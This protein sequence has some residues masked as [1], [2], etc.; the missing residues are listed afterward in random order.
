MDLDNAPNRDELYERIGKA[1]AFLKHKHD[2]KTPEMWYSRRGIL[3]EYPG[4]FSKNGYI[5]MRAKFHEEVFIPE[6][7]I[8]CSRY[9]DNHMKR[10]I[11]RDTISNER[12]KR[13]EIRSPIE[14]ID[15]E[16][17]IHTYHTHYR[18]TALRSFS[19][20]EKNTGKFNSL[21]FDL[22]K[23]RLRLLEKLT[24]KAGC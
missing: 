16:Y 23:K 13:E 14:N 5:E 11:S 18:C 15:N 22:D 1:L 24:Q 6:K 3:E 8:A 10:C 21:I 7:H 2:N 17:T 12:A 4:I 20:N 19:C 9:A